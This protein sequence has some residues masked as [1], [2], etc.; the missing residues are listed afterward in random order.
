M[1][2]QITPACQGLDNGIIV[3][4]NLDLAYACHASL[5]WAASRLTDGGGRPEPMGD[6]WREAS[7][8]QS[9]TYNAFSHGTGDLEGKLSVKKELCR[10]DWL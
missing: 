4:D 2:F 1:C 3:D 10:S 6:L 5:G 7:S 9:V 8:F